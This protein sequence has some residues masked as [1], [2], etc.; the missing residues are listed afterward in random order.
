MVKTLVLDP[1]LNEQ[2]VNLMNN[3]TLANPTN[4]HALG[5]SDTL[6]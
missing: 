3:P 2:E 4:R 5:Q 1:D 6:A